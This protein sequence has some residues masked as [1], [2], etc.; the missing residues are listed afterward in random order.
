MTEKRIQDSCL[1]ALKLIREKNICPEVCMKIIAPVKTSFNCC[2]S[3]MASTSVVSTMDDGLQWRFTL[4]FEEHR[5]IR[6][7][8]KRCALAIK[9]L[10][11]LLPRPIVS[12]TDCLITGSKMPWVFVCLECRRVVFPF[13]FL[14]LENLRGYLVSNT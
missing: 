13:W 8:C 9:C 2:S 11:G 7:C 14:Y 3:C 10:A 6:E 1:Q 12:Y 4:T 5:Q